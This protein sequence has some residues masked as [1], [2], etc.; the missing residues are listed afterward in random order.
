MTITD[1]ELKSIVDSEIHDAVG[2]LTTEVTDDR[3][4]ALKYYFSEPYGDEVEGLSSYVSSDVSDVI[5]SMMPS[6]MRI[7]TSSDDVV[8]IEPEG[9]EDEEF[10]EQ[11]QDFLNW[12]FYKNNP[13]FMLLESAFRDALLSKIGVFKCYWQDDEEVTPENYEGLTEAQLLMLA[14]DDE[15]EILAQAERPD[16]TQPEQPIVDEMGQPLMGE[17]GLPMMQRPVM[18]YDVEARR[19][20]QTGQIKVEV[21]PPEEFLISKRATSLE[22]ADF[23]A[24]QALM[25]VSDL[26]A[27]GYDKDLVM[28][29][30]TGSDT[31]YEEERLN[32]YGEGE[33]P[34][35]DSKDPA[36]REVTVFECYI[37]L[38][39]EEDGIAEWRKVTMAGQ[40]VLDNEPIDDIPFATI[41]P[42]PVPHRFF[43]RSI[44]DLVM[45]TQRLQSVLTRQMLDNCYMTNNSRMIV[46]EGA[47]NMQD[48][49][50]NRAGG[51]IRTKA[52][53]AI[54]P[55]QIPSVISN[56]FPLLQYFRE[57]RDNRTV[58]QDA[59]AVDANVLQ[60]STATAI[61]TMQSAAMSKLELV[62]RNFAETGIKRLFRML[63]K[64]SC[65]N[66]TKAKIIRLRNKFIEMDPTQWN[67]MMDVTI[68]VGLGTNSKD[69]QMAM[70]SMISAKQEQVLMQAGPQNPLVG[71]EEYRNTLRRMVE[72]AGFKGVDQ[73]VKPEGQMPPP[74]QQ[75]PPG[76]SPEEQKAMAEIE[77]AKAKMEADIQ[78]R[79]EKMAQDLQLEREKLQMEMEL[80][81]QE[82]QAELQLKSIKATQDIGEGSNIRSVV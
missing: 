46:Q 79:R 51:I 75:Q 63:L 17:G 66:E 45:P 60:N 49:L 80:K 65:Q 10:A 62:A 72:L 82:L 77:I 32:R 5:E 7:F 74:Q 18:L 11:A 30:P 67:H 4:D 76:P 8:E 58:G 50:T 57:E 53:G 31:M 42:I 40:E 15:I 13:G 16:P 55:L 81:T 9:P 39:L 43:G 36:M 24:H 29:L 14:D 35:S 33:V 52:Q 23:V 37:K 70:L 27:A 54:Q 41:C 64:L 1:Q 22:D 12:V 28:S 34:D 3:S 19:T 38:D 68:N 26:I 25:T 44:A 78:L 71:M 2:Y 61:A 20:K 47:V 48:V 69:Q 56:V 73:Y 6:L 59:S 21:V